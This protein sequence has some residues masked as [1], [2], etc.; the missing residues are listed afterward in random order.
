MLRSDDCALLVDMPAAA[1]SPAGKQGPRGY[2]RGR[3]AG[4]PIL[5]L[6]ALRAAR[7]SRALQLSWVGLVRR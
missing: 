2:A 4:R 5:S 3:S 1:V 7:Q 6:T